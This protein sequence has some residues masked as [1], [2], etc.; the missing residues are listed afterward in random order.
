M[1]CAAD[2]RLV[3][4]DHVPCLHGSGADAPRGQNEPGLQGTHS[5]APASPWKLPGLQR[6]HKADPFAEVTVPGRQDTQ[7]AALLLPGIGFAVPGGQLRQ[8]ALFE[9]PL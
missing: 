6:T 2:D 3:P 4:L 9:L 1:H 8:D 7:A 5:C